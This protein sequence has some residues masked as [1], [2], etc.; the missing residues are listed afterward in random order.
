[1]RTLSATHPSDFEQLGTKGLRSRFLVDD[2]FGDQVTWTYALDDRILLGG[3]ELGAER[4]EVVGP[5]ELH[6]SSLCAR[7]ELAV[8]PLSGPMRVTADG[9]DYD[10]GALDV[11]YIGLGTGEITVQGSG[12]VFLVSTPAHH[13]HPTALARRADVAGTELGEAEHAN[14]RTI[15]RHI[16]A[17]GVASSNLVLGVTT[18]HPGS[19]WNTMP[20]HTHAR[21]TEVYLYTG[22]GDNGQVVHFAGPPHCTRSLVMTDDQAVVSP[23]WS[24][25][26]GVGTRSYSFIWAMAGENQDYTDMDPVDLSELQ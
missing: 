6:S 22:L 7:R 25:H 18:L 8:V 24:I 10:L 19:V 4:V 11:L 16:H 14:V 23:G 3:L 21:R 12:R 17:D 2:L 9:T 26:T 1:M 13:R 20:P 15:R 5:A